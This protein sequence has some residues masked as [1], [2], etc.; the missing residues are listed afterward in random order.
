MDSLVDCDNIDSWVTGD[1]AMDEDKGEGDDKSDED[2]NY[3]EFYYDPALDGTREALPPH[4]SSLLRPC[5]TPDLIRL[6]RSHRSSVAQLRLLVTYSGHSRTDNLPLST[7]LVLYSIHSL[8]HLAVC[9]A[10][11]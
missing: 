8:P 6:L 5:P 3:Q 2:G 11:T 10:L 4:F 9:P 7:T 1:L